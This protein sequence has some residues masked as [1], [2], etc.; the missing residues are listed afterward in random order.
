M[1]SRKLLSRKI[2]SQKGPKFEH[3]GAEQQMIRQKR[4]QNLY[5]KTKTLEVIGKP[6]YLERFE[7]V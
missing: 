4:P 5:E 7:L 2:L 6:I 1:Q 3:R